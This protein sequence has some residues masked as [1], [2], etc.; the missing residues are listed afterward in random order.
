MLELPANQYLA[1]ACIT[2]LLLLNRSESLSLDSFTKLPLLNYAAT[3]WQ[4][5][6]KI[7]FQ[8]GYREESAEG[9]LCDVLRLLD[10]SQGSAYLNWLRVSD[11]DEWNQHDLSKRGQDVP[12]SLYYTSLL[13]LYI[14]TEALINRGVDVNARGGLFGNAL[15]AAAFRNHHQ[16]VHLL[17]RNGAEIKLNEGLHY[18]ALNAAAV[19]GSEAS[20]RILLELCFTGRSNDC[21]VIGSSLVAA[22]AS[23][24]VEIVRLLL[25]SG[26]DV[27]FQGN[28]SVRLNSI[29]AGSPIAAASFQGHKDVVQLLIAE[30]ADV[31]A[32][33]GR[34]GNPLQTASRAGFD[35]L[36][37]LLLDHGADINAQG[38]VYGT[39]LQ[40]ASASGHQSTVRL[41]LE[42]GA[43]DTH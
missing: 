9:F 5:H 31:N 28:D 17:L 43:N 15:Q 23:G 10:Q 24:N 13:G 3:H 39:A 34:Y 37:K 18:S 6:A 33:G 22:P 42:R 32:K 20:F 4:D 1:H 35:S 8:E 16:I 36:V 38:G 21:Q 7:A 27:N 2:Y 30:G 12:K 19:N 41:L 40:A 11:P 25:E 26:A 29:L 14:V